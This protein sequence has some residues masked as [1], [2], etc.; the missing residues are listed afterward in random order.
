VSHWA[1]VYPLLSLWLFREALAVSQ[2]R[3]ADLGRALRQPLLGALA[4]L[5]VVS[6][7]RLPLLAQGV[8]SLVTLVVC[9]TVGSVVYLAFL[10]YVDRD[11]MAEIRQVLTDFG[12]PAG[13]LD[14]WP[15]NR[16]DAKQGAA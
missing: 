13:K 16:A 9:I 5:A 14:R 8:P 7:L 3:F 6:L 11:G 2:L 10:I 1:L 15:F 4:M 12:V